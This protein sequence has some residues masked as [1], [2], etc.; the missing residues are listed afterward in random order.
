MKVVF[1]RRRW[2]RFSYEVSHG[3]TVTQKKTEDLVEFSNTVGVNYTINVFK[4]SIY[5]TPLCY[6]GIINPFL[7]FSRFKR[8][9][10][11]KGAAEVLSFKQ[12]EFCLDKRDG[13]LC[14]VPGD[15]IKCSDSRGVSDLRIKTKNVS[16]KV[17]RRYAVTNIGNAVFWFLAFAVLVLL[18]DAETDI[19]TT[20]AFLLVSAG[21]SAYSVFSVLRQIKK[22]WGR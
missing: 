21:L 2:Q 1:K 15:E 17:R 20:V 5:N 7:Y 10:N 16:S 22:T 6:L 9:D 12:V 3:G 13:Y 19:G 4:K 8:S 11:P 14:F 18:L